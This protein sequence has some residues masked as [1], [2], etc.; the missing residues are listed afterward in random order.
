MFLWS[1]L[2]FCWQSSNNPSRSDSSLQEWTWLPGY[3]CVYETKMRQTGEKFM[4][5][6][7]KNLI[8]FSISVGSIWSLQPEES[9]LDI[10][11]TC[12]NIYME[13]AFFFSII[14][15]L[16]NNVRQLWRET[17]KWTCESVIFSVK[18]SRLTACDTV[19]R[20]C[21]HQ[22]RDILQLMES[23]KST[24]ADRL[25]NTLFICHSTIILHSQLTR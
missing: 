3:I 24:T 9:E 8:P 13:S 10:S 21:S 2:S 1:H 12:S 5:G 11:Q 23:F 16:R 17:T 19:H 22:R 14:C 7:M 20:D 18:I 15:T 4:F 6:K 25:P